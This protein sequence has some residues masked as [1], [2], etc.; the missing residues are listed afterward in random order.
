MIKKVLMSK[1]FRCEKC[2]NNVEKD[3]RGK[4]MLKEKRGAKSSI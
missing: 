1:I 2:Q 4:G 3:V